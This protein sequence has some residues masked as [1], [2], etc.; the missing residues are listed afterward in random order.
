MDSILNYLNFG[1]ALDERKAQSYILD[2]IDSKDFFNKIAYIK[3]RSFKDLLCLATDNT[4]KTNVGED[5]YI[6]LS[7]GLDSRALLAALLDIKE[8]NKIKAITFGNDNH[9]DRVFSQKICEKNNIE[10]LCF[11]FNKYS[12]NL[13]ELVDFAKDQFNVSGVLDSIQTIQTNSTI[14][15]KHF[16]NEKIIHG[17]FGDAIAKPQYNVKYNNIDKNLEMFDL[18]NTVNGFIKY[19]SQ[20]NFFSLSELDKVQ[21][22]FTRFLIKNLDLIEV[23]PGL[24]TYDILNVGFRQGLRIRPDYNYMTNI[25]TPFEHKYW[26]YYWLSQDLETRKNNTFYKENLFKY[27]PKIFPDLN[28]ISI[29]KIVL[30]KQKLQNKYFSGRIPDLKGDPAINSSLKNIYSELLKSLEDRRV[31]D[32][33]FSRD[34]SKWIDNNDQRAGNRVKW[35]SSLEIHILAGNLKY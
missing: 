31:L 10:Q 1:F 30:F 32:Y 22:F 7:A 29:S 34:L 25:L 24:S 20:F 8:T 9:Y 27:F 11:D 16:K 4:I 3:N 33:N 15:S 2:K 26:V 18:A 5:V 28:Y 17:Y 6:S 14:Y 12:W 21:E 19:N 35:G 23:F 13:N